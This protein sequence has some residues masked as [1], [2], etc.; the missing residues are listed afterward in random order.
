[1][2]LN[3]SKNT[4]FKS[5]VRETYTFHASVIL[6]YSPQKEKTVTNIAHFSNRTSGLYIFTC[7][8]DYMRVWI[9]M[10]HLQLITIS[11]NKCL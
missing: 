5:E 3:S 10:G 6:S 8:S 7:L 9:G 11:N 2:Y 1:M 4:T